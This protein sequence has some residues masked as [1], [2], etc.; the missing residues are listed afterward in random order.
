MPS[1][2]RDS[3]S[4]RR[5]AS[6]PS[7]IWNLVGQGI[8]LGISIVVSLALLALCA[9]LVVYAH[10]AR[11]LP[12]PDELY[13]RT[14][15]FQSVKIYDRHG[16]LLHEFMDPHGGRR[17]VTPYEDIPSVVIEATVA[18]EDATFFAN[19]GI[20]P[21]AI[22]RSVFLALQ[23]GTA[24]SGGSTITQ[25]VVKN[26]FLSPE[27]TLSRKIKEAIL[28]T[29]LTRRYSKGEILTVYLNDAYFGN[30]AYGIA[31]ASE[32][33]F[34]KGVADL[35]LHEAALLA[36]LIQS[37]VLYDPYTRPDAALARREI[38][39]DLMAKR[40]YISAGVAEDAQAMP[41]GV[42]T[43]TDSIKA[44][45]MVMYVWEII[46]GMYGEDGL[47]AEGLRVYTTLDLEMQTVAEAS[48]SEGIASLQGR[49]AGNGALVALDPA[50]GD[51]LAMV[52]SADFW[53]EAISGQINMTS[54]PRQPG[55]TIKP[56][57]YLAALERGW[58]AATMVMDVAQEFPDG[59][60]PPYRPVNYDG[61]T[62]GPM[63]IR[64][65]LACSRNIPAVSVLNQVG[66]DAL[67]NVCQRLGI[68]SLTGTQYGLSLTLG[69]GEVSLLEMTAAYGALANG[70]QMVTPRAILRIEDS[71]GNRLYAPES[72]TPTLVMDPRHAY[73]LTDMLA[74]EEARI[75]AFGPESPLD[76]GFP[77]AVK[78]GTTND[79]RDAWTIGYTPHLVTGVWVGNCDNH[80]MDHVTGVRGAGPVWSRF[81]SGVPLNADHA[82]FSRPEG[83]VEVEVC[84]VSGQLPSDDCTDVRTETFLVENAPTALCG[85][86]VRRAIC[87]ESGKLATDDCPSDKVEEQIFTDYGLAWDAWAQE[88]GLQTPP[89]ESC[90]VHTQ[91]TLPGPTNETDQGALSSQTR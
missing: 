80:P 76:L 22:L 90:D 81:M 41:L 73:L 27:Q 4:S 51:I 71:Q 32:L 34:D 85:V 66:L 83:L 65:A 55:S 50:N 52:G 26:H 21:V 77:A 5:L 3:A 58:T 64:T 19:P 45:H 62:W 47:Y 68:H 84:A 46:Q 40:G 88:Q 57:T 82:P 6:R 70:G 7:S 67:L 17:I 30:L 56:F 39:L 25:Q 49:E 29:E 72:M 11:L 89:R 10:Y 38:V 33:Y 43:P 69:G 15:Q 35:D 1:P 79:F 18:T 86:H 53:D 16:V 48:V 75:P 78:T 87:T 91:N 28:A 12:S 14:T 9:G 8:V 20:E 74:D 36:G 23:E 54:S 2:F 13:A 61:E 63:S 37:P 59:A 44:P 60:N 42:A 24:V 31:A